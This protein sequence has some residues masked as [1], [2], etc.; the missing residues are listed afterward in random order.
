MVL[1]IA[2]MRK[3]D[4]NLRLKVIQSNW[5]LELKIGKLLAV[6]HGYDTNNL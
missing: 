2:E 1:R 6:E 3:G 4:H 5:R